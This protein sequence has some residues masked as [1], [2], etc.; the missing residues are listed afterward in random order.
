MRILHLINNLRREGAQVVAFNLVT[1]AAGAAARHAVCVRTPGGAL[2]AA[3]EAKGIPVFS[4]RR[5][6]GALGSRHVLRLVDRV[7]QEEG[8]DLVHAHMADCAVLAALAAARRGL[9]LVITHHGQDILPDCGGGKT[10]R[11]VYAV[12]LAIAARYA[13]RNVAVAPAVAEVVMR[14]L[15]LGRKRVEVIVNGV[16]V[17]ALEPTGAARAAAKRPRIVS[18]GRLVELKGQEQLIAA[19]ARVAERYDDLQVVFVGD[20]P[21]RA[22]LGR[23]AQALGV[24]ERVIFTGVV[25]DVDAHLRGGDV[26]VSTSR[27]E[28]MPLAILEA[29]GSML[30]VVASDVAGNRAV[31]HHRETGLLYPAGDVE[32]LAQAI[33]QMV[34]HPAAARAYAQRARRMVEERYSADAAARAYARLYVDVLHGAPPRVMP[35]S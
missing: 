12:L 35:V 24:A 28:G 10:C 2:Q 17:P 20:G 19:A 1:C 22:E 6:Y 30:P 21:L 33:T 29:M 16:R 14:R 4:P 15:L 25:D 34:D 13:R 31:V 18:V 3:L 7:I 23:K 32:A 26:Y 11:M 27:R 5:Y 8:I 9:P